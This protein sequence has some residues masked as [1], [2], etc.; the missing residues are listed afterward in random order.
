MSN[1]SKRLIASL[2]A[3]TKKPRGIIK[4]TRMAA[5]RR[6]MLERLRSKALVRPIN[7]NLLNLTKVKGPYVQWMELIKI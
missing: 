2:V 6:K 7:L 1:L 4:P 5:F 3:N